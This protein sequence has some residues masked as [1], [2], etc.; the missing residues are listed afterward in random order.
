MAAN[1]PTE[2]G[3]MAPS[4]PP[5]IAA[6]DGAEG[7]ADGVRRA[8]A[9]RCGGFV[10]PLGAVLDGNMAGS[11]VDDRRGDEERRDLARAAIHQR[12]V[13]AL[14]DIEAADPGTDVYTDGLGILGRDHQA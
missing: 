5:A 14:D 6:L 3:V 12:R 13:F 4:A 1:P 7:V 10:R 11:Q 2:S 9:G 8:G